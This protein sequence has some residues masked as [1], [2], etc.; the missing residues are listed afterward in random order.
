M[1]FWRKKSVQELQQEAG[2]DIG[3]KRVLG[4]IDLIA[5]EIGAIVG[6]GI[7]VLTGQAAANYAGPAIVFS[8]VFENARRPTA[9]HLQPDHIQKKT[10]SEN[11]AGS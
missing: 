1:K 10:I 8:S 3:L 9:H 7:F 2:T 6:A 4:P 11:P 5:I